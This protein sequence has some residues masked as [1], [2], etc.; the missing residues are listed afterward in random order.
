MPLDNPYDDAEAAW[1]QL[2]AAA[3]R[4]QDAANL[5][6]DGDRS[7]DGYEIERALRRHRPELLAK[8]L[9]GLRQ[10]RKDAKV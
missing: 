6:K 8:H 1:E 3:K 9:D 5:I 10:H 4:L 7:V 2:I